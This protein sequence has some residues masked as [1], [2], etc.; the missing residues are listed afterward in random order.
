MKFHVSCNLVFLFNVGPG[1]GFFCN[2]WKLCAMLPR[3]LQQPVKNKNRR[4]IMLLRRQS[5]DLRNIIRS[6]L[7]NIAQGFYLHNFVPR[8]LRQH[9][10]RIFPVQCC[11]QPL[12]QHWARF[13]PVHCY[14]KSSIKTTLNSISSCALLSGAS[15]T[16]LHRVFS[17]VILFQEY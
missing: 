6:L 13:L 8:E 10:K 5:T 16:T 2:V 1:F 9:W 14:P 3:H 11:L 7:G 4:N 15:R 17:C 12:R